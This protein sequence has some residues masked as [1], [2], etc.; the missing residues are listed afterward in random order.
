MYAAE[1]FVYPSVPSLAP[2][3]HYQVRVRA[4][5]GEWQSAFAWETACKSIEKKTD[6]YFD[7]LAD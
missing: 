4:I 1:L 7:T 3:E 6:A 2:S 5:G